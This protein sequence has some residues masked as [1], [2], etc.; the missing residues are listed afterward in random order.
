VFITNHVLAGAAVGHVVR[1]PAAA[2]V[3]GAASHVVMDL[4][5]HYGRDDVT[6]NEFVKLARVDGVVGLGVCA[7]A[8]ATAHGPVRPS[9]AAGIAGAC[10]IDM[11]K[12]GRHFFGR[13]PFPAAVDRFHD[14]IQTEHTVGALVEA[15]AAA[16]LAAAVVAKVRRVRVAHST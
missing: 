2:F 3:A 11:D 8:L 13:S 16:V 14:W 9:V 5:L 6:R 15:A 12:P 7:V 4:C 10:L 1:R